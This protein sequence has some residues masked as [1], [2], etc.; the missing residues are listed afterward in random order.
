MSA[1]GDSHRPRIVFSLDW[2]TRPVFGILLAAV[3]IAATIGG[4]PW[5]A[6]FIAVMVIAAAREYHRI[7]MR[8]GYLVGF[9]VTGVAT[10]AMVYA[11]FFS[12]LSLLPWAILVAGVALNFLLARVVG[13]RP[14]WTAAGVI[15]LCVPAYCATLVRGVPHGIWV[16]VG[17]LFAIWATDTGAL[18]AG[19]L[20]GGPKLAPVVSPNKTWAGTLGGIA[21][22]AVIEA[23]IIALLKGDVVLGAVYGAGIA[24]AAHAGDLLESWIKRQF[25]RKDSGT[26]I[27]GHGGV[28]D[29]IDSTLSATVAVAAVLFIAQINPLFGALP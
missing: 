10:L 7:A 19:N 14:L 20:I 13:E 15:Y 27:P 22:A 5:F 2:I 21:A 9:A 12:S 4:G 25:N 3:A 26:L 24:V 11:P 6:L 28:L 23:V 29:R 8:N 1:V 18:I 17:L 16:I